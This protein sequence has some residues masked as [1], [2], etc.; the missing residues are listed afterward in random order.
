[1]TLGEVVAILS[2]RFSD[3]D[4]RVSSLESRMTAEETL[5][6]SL[7]S[8]INSI[9]TGSGVSIAQVISY[10]QSNGLWFG[11]NWWVGEYQSYLY[12]MDV[13]TNSSYVFSPDVNRDL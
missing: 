11:N 5:T 9:T 7:Q 4:S 3:L 13:A 6:T 2:S 1:M 10:I 8:Q 12:A